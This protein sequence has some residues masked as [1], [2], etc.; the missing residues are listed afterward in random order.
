MSPWHHFQEDNG[1]LSES[2]NNWLNNCLVNVNDSPAA[3]LYVGPNREVNEEIGAVAVL[4]ELVGCVDPAEILLV[5]VIS[6]E[7]RFVKAAMTLPTL[8]IA[9]KVYL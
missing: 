6:L 4:T 3:Q 7:S 2:S 5:P 1:L 9:M 8:A